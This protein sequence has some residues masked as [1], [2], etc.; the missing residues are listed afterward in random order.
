MIKTPANVAAAGALWP[1]GTRP[2]VELN[3]FNVPDLSDVEDVFAVIGEVE[4][5]RYCFHQDWWWNVLNVIGIP[6]NEEALPLSR[7]R[8]TDSSR[9][10]RVVGWRRNMAAAVGF[11]GS[12]MVAFITVK[13]LL[14]YVQTHRFTPFAW[15][16]IGFGLL[17][18]NSSGCLSATQQ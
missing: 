4:E 8:E 13:W 3:Y 5:H 7:R 18:C 1:S 2:S 14:V 6:L 11:A 15:Y 16:R 10:D 17:L 9:A 12:A